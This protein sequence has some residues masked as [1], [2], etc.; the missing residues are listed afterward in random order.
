MK[1]L[2]IVCDGKRQKYGDFLAQLISLRRGVIGV[3]KIGY[4]T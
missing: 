3:S 1:N 4:L 2:I